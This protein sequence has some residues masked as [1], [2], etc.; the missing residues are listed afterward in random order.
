MKDSAEYSTSSA[1]SMS[2]RRGSIFGLPYLLWISSSSS[3]TSFQ[4]PSSSLSR[5]AICRDRLRFSA[6]SFWITRISSRASRYSFSSRMASVCSAS[7]EN[8]SMIFSAESALPS[9]LRMILMI[10]SSA[11]NTFSKPSRM[12]MRLLQLLELVLQAVGHH[13]Q[14]EVEEVPEHLLEIEPLG[15][16]DLGVLGR[17]QARHVHG[18]RRLQR[19]VLEQIRHHEV[20]V[21]AGLQV[22]L[23]PHVVGR[24]VAHVD[25]MRHLAA[26]H[27]VADLLDQLRL[28]DRV[29]NARDVELLVRAGRRSGFPGGSAGGSTRSRSGRSPSARPASSGCDRRSENRDP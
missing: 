11:S 13:F 22:E 16:A 14:A 4:R 25:E 21:G 29:G 8:R 17:H 3:R 2:E 5:P 20:V 7:S 10:S 1:S 9:D 26:E 19:R 28:V 18:E 24:H 6:S 12:W 15:A 23:D 27:D